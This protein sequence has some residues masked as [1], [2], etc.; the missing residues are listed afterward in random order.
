MEKTKRN[1]VLTGLL[2]ML[3]MFGL[4]LCFGL[5]SQVQTVYATGGE[6]NPKATASQVSIYGYS[7][8]AIAGIEFADGVINI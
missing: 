7:P 5:N 2:A 3:M 4:C 6:P 8:V 1:W